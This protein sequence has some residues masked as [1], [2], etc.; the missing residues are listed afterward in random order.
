[1]LES[2]SSQS[3]TKNHLLQACLVQLSPQHHPP[4][5]E[6]RAFQ[7]ASIQVA[8]H[9][10]IHR[11][12]SSWSH[13]RWSSSHLQTWSATCWCR[14]QTRAHWPWPTW[15]SLPFQGKAWAVSAKKKRQRHRTTLSVPCRRVP[16]KL[17][18]SSEALVALHAWAQDRPVFCSFEHRWTR[19]VAWRQSQGRQASQ[20]RAWCHLACRTRFQSSETGNLSVSNLGRRDPCWFTLLHQRLWREAGLLHL[21]CKRLTSSFDLTHR[22]PLW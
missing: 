6:S 9:Q 4:L 10:R 2:M 14:W 22:L 18:L 19:Q 1:M 12:R 8:C 16:R 20:S 11:A 17:P 3:L 7:T 5:S 21:C 15:T 13:Q